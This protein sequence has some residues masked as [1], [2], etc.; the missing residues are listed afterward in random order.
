MIV[1]T[2][3]TF[4]LFHAGH[5]IFLKRCAKLGDVYVSLNTDEFIAEYKGYPPVMNYEERREVLMSCEYVKDV[6]PNT[7][8]ADSKPAIESI[9]PD[10]IAIGSDWAGR[11]YYEQMSFT[12]EWLDDKDILLVYLPYTIGISTTDIKK[13]LC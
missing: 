6:I 3:G 2:G 11:D 8:G 13:R 12:Q 7:G 4:D 1:Y 10:I 9:D 5:V